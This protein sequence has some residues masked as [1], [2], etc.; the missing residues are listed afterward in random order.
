MLFTQIL[1]ESTH[2]VAHELGLGM[3]LLQPDGEVK[4]MMMSGISADRSTTVACSWPCTLPCCRQ[5]LVRVLL[6]GILITDKCLQSSSI[7]RLVVTVRERLKRRSTG[8]FCGVF[9]LQ[10]IVGPSS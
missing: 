10:H 6:Y 1:L 3:V 9:V 5:C 4:V 8:F 7:R 2:V